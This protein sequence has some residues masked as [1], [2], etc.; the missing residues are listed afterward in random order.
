MINKK[1][2]TD[3]AMND[4]RIN[5]F[6]DIHDVDYNGILRTS[7]ALK[8]M[9][10]AAQ[11]QLNS[12]GLSYDELKRQN[13]A[14]ILSKVKLE[15]YK[16][17]YAYQPYTATTY[18]CESRGYSFLRCH[19][20]ER[21]GEVIARAAS[22]WAL[23]DTENRALVRVNDFE[24]NLPLL[25]HNNV[26]PDLIRAP[27]DKLVSV[28]SFSVRYCDTDQNR[29]MNNTRYP[30]MYSEFLPLENRMIRSLTIH[31]T[32]EAPI[33]ENMRVLRAENDGVYYFRSIRADGKINT[34]AK[35][36]LVEI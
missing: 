26:V 33:G 25:P 5:G 7:S 29:H 20:L 30:D 23:I 15:I 27:I 11:E 32:N 24:L 28:G 2:K 19:S 22:V 35:L 36:E 21:D 14:F 8:Y 31:Y 9:Q 18:P 13:R 6:V 3:T 34:E 10:N 4:Y 12:R 17:L 1:Q 16:P